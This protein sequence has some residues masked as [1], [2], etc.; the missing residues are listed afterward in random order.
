MKKQMM[1]AAAVLM[2]A[3]AVWGADTPTPTVATAK[4]SPDA[5][6]LM[7]EMTS[8]YGQLH[9]LQLSG[10]FS[11]D[12]DIGGEPRKEKED[13]SGTF[14]APNRFKHEMKDDLASGSTGEKFYGYAKKPNLYFTTALPPAGGQL[15]SGDLPDSI[16][17][18]LH[19]QNPGLLL[20]ISKDA[21]QSMKAE[22]TEISTASPTV[23]NGASYDTLL[24][25]RGADKPSTKLLLDPKTHL[26]RQTQ[27]DL[28]P[29]LVHRGAPDVKKAII[30]VD[31]A[32]VTPDAPVTDAA[33]AWNAPA[34]AREQAQTTGA[35]DVDG[36]VKDLIGKAAPD[37]TLKQLDG[38]DVKLSGLKGSVVVLDFWATWCGP[39]VAGLPHVDGIYKDNK[40]KGVKA[41]AVNMQE[42]S[43]KVKAFVEEKKLTLPVL[44]E[45]KGDVAEKYKVE[46]IPETVVIGKDGIVKKV[47]VGTGPDTEEQLRAAV[48]AAMKG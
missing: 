11:A 7:G 37:F 47:F 18:M 45:P 3:G 10:T 44:L 27:T 40:D 39:C 26:I 1:A 4:V 20:A 46:G 2:A 29:E 9:S 19:E 33:F 43:D 36:A 34:G 14:E 15:M 31:Y 48:E 32:L 28:S 35:D 24:V 16:R 42:E 22:A 17:S 5:Q 23:L 13:I 8:A 12:F 25:L 6:K 38:T 21:E 41:F 30:T